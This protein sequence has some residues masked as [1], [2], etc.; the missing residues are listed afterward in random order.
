[1]VSSIRWVLEIRPVTGT[2]PT[3]SISRTICSARSGSGVDG[4]RKLST[5]RHS[6]SSNGTTSDSDPRTRAPTSSPPTS[7][8]RRRL[9]SRR[10][11]RICGTMIGRSAW[12]LA[13]V[14]ASS[15]MPASG[16]NGAGRAR[17]EVG[18]DDIEI[19]QGDRHPGGGQI[20]RAVE[21]DLGLAAAE[22]ADENCHPFPIQT[23]SPTQ[24]NSRIRG[25]S[26]TRPAPLRQGM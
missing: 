25:I 23:L 2:R 22:V 10:W 15:S 20:E 26:I 3:A 7:M 8:I 5:S 17:P 1:M 16:E 12:M 11:L 13:P 4:R 9:G 24:G 6:V 19:G 14:G 21:R 18:F